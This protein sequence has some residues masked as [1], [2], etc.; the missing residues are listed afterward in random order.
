M[1]SIVYSDRKVMMM[2]LNKAIDHGKEKRKPYIGAKATDCTCRNH[3]TCKW[4]EENRRHKFRDKH[5]ADIGT[6][7]CSVW[8]ETE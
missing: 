6:G 5:P 7:E 4:C 3:G 1:Y 8:E 2:S